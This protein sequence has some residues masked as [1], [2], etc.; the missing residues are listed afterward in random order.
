MTRQLYTKPF[1]IVLI[2]VVTLLLDCFILL[3]ERDSLIFL[4]YQ[5]S[6]VFSVSKDKITLIEDTYCVDLPYILILPHDVPAWVEDS[7]KN[8][9]Y[10]QAPRFTVQTDFFH[11][12]SQSSCTNAGTDNLCC[13]ATAFTLI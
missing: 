1:S 9:S 13:K 5:K 6:G 7:I 8:L 2:A 11:L 12:L 3:L 10:S 4:I